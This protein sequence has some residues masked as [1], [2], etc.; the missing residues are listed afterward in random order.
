MKIGYARVST[1][2]QDLGLQIDKLTEYGCER[3]FS[4][5]ISGATLDRPELNKMLD[6]LRD[7]DEVVV[8]K[9]DRLSRKMRHSLTLIETFMEKGVTFVAVSQGLRYDNTAVG[10]LMF[11]QLATYAEFERDITAER[12]RE[13]I[14]RSRA[15]GVRMGRPPALTPDQ[16]E[17]VVMLIRKGRS[18]RSVATEMGC[19]RKTIKR[20]LNR[21][22]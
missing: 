20:I 16:C 10:K 3:I 11:N 7:G 5:H 8:W 2:D 22:T 19:S 14:K 1:D 13:G 12:I 15:Q 18:V 4:E 6:H 17:T 21:E 9:V